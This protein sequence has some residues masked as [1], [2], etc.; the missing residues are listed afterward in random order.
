MTSKN[1]LIFGGTNGIG[2]FLVKELLKSKNN[3]TLVVR[4]IDK[5][6]LLFNEEVELVEVD[7]ENSNT[8]LE[9]LNKIEINSKFDGLIYTAGIEGTFP[10]KSASHEKLIKYYNINTI[11]FHLA[12]SFFSKKKISNDSSSIV[13][14][15]SIMSTIGASGK[16]VYSASKS[17]LNGLV[18]SAALELSSRK[19]RVNAISPGLTL[20]DMG[21]ALLD[22]MSNSDQDKLLKEY[23]LGL[24]KSEYIS[25]LI[26]FLLSDKS[27]WIT[28]QNLTIDGG[29]TIK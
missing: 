7:L 2:L 26:I 1:Y 17:S 14:I 27:I 5:A 28:G 12:L 20:T 29:Y 4:N 10:L 25:D 15:S 24:G 9:T 18:R 13:V 3:L 8:L 23:P 22:R 6:R 21:N 16:S 19:I 11:S